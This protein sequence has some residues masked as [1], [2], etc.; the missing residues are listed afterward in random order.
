VV[1]GAR[2]VAARRTGLNGKRKNVARWQTAFS[3]TKVHGT[4]CVLET[5]RRK[6]NA[7]VFFRGGNYTNFE[8]IATVNLYSAEL[9]RTKNVASKC[10]PSLGPVWFP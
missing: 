7:G 4:H 1:S 5:I 9:C 2:T 3:S 10:Q 6:K 8:L